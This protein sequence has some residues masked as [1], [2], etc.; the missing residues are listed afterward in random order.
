M[1]L[2]ELSPE[3]S[4]LEV[5]L[6]HQ[7]A[8]ETLQAFTSIH[9]DEEGS[10][11]GETDPKS[12]DDDEENY[13]KEVPVSIVG[14]LEKHKFSRSEGVHGGECNSGDKGAKEASPKGL[15]VE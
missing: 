13:L 2:Q 14:D 11:G 10:D 4:D 3:R 8:V 5:E 9:I 12:T 15:D 1:I 7:S 6:D